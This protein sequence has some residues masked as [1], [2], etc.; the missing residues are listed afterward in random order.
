MYQSGAAE[1]VDLVS[2][3]LLTA[4]LQPATDIT[5]L[6]R[7][8]EKR[9]LLRKVTSHDELLRPTIEAYINSIPASERA[10]LLR[11]R[12]LAF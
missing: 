12:G 9:V 6:K 3:V 8:A 2:G 7:A 1:T 10:R 11:M 4:V 5:E